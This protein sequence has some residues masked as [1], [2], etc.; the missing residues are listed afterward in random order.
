MGTLFGE[1]VEKRKQIGKSIIEY[2]NVS[3]I[4]TKT[5][6][7]MNGYDY[8]MNPYSGCS[9]G[10][11]YCYAAFFSRSDDKKNNW[12]YWIDVKENALSLL[13]KLR[14][15]PL[16]KKTIYI[17]SVTDPY[18]PIEK[19]LEL[20]RSLLKELSEYHKPIIVIQTRSPL[21]TRDLD[22]FKR[23]D[24][25]QIN[26]TITTDSEEVRK[27]FEPLCPSNKVRLNAIKEINDSGIN[28]CI[29]MTPLLP[30]KNAEEFAK[31]LLETEIKKFIVQPFH[32]ERGKFIA[33]TR[34]EAMKL[35]KEM[36][37]N[38]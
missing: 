13:I 18:Q 34:E 15:K 26:M 4:L 23:F 28:A 5:S 20:T 17:S 19:E 12:G 6:G 32:S 11:T 8:T 30:I 16:I 21:V 22:L 14:R 31:Q 38:R 7:F 27:I 3:S 10:C 29:T 2:K 25:I 33:G 9:F 35:V 36:N 37:W 1:E 24:K